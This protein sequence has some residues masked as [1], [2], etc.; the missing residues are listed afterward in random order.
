MS[1][2]WKHRE[3]TYHGSKWGYAVVALVIVVFLALLGSIFYILGQGIKSMSGMEPATIVF[4][5]GVGVGVGVLVI[6]VLVKLGIIAAATVMFVYTGLKTLILAP[7]WTLFTN[8]YL[9]IVVL[10]IAAILVFAMF[11][12]AQGH[13][14]ISLANPVVIVVLAVLL[15]LFFPLAIFLIDQ[16]SYEHE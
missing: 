16:F 10:I 15:I 13:V 8:I 7:I 9:L 12:A 1:Q 6:I 5:T 3:E 14:E 2:T 11:T 4:Y